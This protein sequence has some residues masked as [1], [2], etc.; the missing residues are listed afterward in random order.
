MSDNVPPHYQG[1]WRRILLT[2]PGVHDDTTRVVWM[3]T[4]QWHADLRIPADRPPCEGRTSL[5]DCNRDELLGLLRQEGFA[6]I[7]KVQGDTCEWLRRLDYRPTGRRDLGSMA[8]S[9]DFDAIDEVGIEA[10]Y[11]ERWVREPQGSGEQ[12]MVFT[13]DVHAPKLC[14]FSGHCFMRVQDRALHADAARR[15]WQ[16]VQDGTAHDEELRQLADFEISFGDIAHGQ[17][18]IIHSTLPWLEGVRLKL[19]GPARSG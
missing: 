16:R 14:L 1:L 11:A 2:A 7:T 13:H 9:S 6:G 18:R 8:F 15:A 19:S 10:N 3:Q 17:G 12:H 4:A 5:H